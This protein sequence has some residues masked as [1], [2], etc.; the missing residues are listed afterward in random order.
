[1]GLKAASAPKTRPKKAASALRYAIKEKSAS[2]ASEKASGDEN[3]CF[4]VK[5]RGCRKRAALQKAAFASENGGPGPPRGGWQRAV[6]RFCSGF[7]PSSGAASPT[8]LS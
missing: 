4:S 1:M 5:R 6:E 3:A 8:P 7:A 2:F